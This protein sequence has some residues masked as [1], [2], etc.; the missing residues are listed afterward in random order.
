MI[1]VVNKTER[2][3]KYWL[4][5]YLFRIICVKWQTFYCGLNVNWKMVGEMVWNGR[6]GGEIYCSA[7]QFYK[8]LVF[9][10]P[11]MNV[12][13]QVHEEKVSIIIQCYFEILLFSHYLFFKKI[14]VCGH[15]NL[16]LLSQQY[17]NRKIYTIWKC[18]EFKS[19]V[20]FRWGNELQLNKLLAFNWSFQL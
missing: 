7:F 19:I 11:E 10:M 6:W 16:P 15:W 18:N 4:C 17:R 2:Y 3:N 13:Q 1:E 20:V 9:D 12:D 14:D 8:V 5:F